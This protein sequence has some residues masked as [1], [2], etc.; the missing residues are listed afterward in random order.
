MRYAPVASCDDSMLRAST[1][2]VPESMELVYLIKES[3]VLVDEEA[4][5]TLVDAGRE[6]HGDGDAAFQCESG[7]CLVRPRSSVG[8]QLDLRWQRADEPLQFSFPNGSVEWSEPSPN[9]ADALPHLHH[10]S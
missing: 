7:H 6:E 8:D 1:L 4:R 2:A 9:Y 10:C 5:V 3:V